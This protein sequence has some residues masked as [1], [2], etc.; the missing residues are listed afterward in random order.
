MNLKVAI[1]CRILVKMRHLN[2]TT[3]DNYTSNL[4]HKWHIRILQFGAK[5]FPYVA[6][7]KGII[8]QSIL[9][10]ISSSSNWLLSES[11]SLT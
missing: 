5:F 7:L 6:S 3:T 4:L 9:R 1:T 11:D 8:Q 2:I 10:Q